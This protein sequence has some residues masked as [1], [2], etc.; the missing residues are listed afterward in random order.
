MISK[1]NVYSVSTLF[2]K[3]RERIIEFV[4]DNPNRKAKVRE[5]AKQ[6]RLGGPGHWR[7]V[8]KRTEILKKCFQ[9]PSPVVGF[10]SRFL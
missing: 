10:C 4:L 9:L 5:L 3:D 8:G 7:A 2:P 1:Q 6:F